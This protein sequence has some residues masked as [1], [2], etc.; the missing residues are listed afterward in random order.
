MAI[1]SLSCLRSVERGYSFSPTKCA[2]ISNDSAPK[3][4]YG[5]DLSKVKSFCYLGIDFTACGIDEIGNAKRRTAKADGVIKSLARLGV[6]SPVL[7]A[8]SLVQL[9]KSLVR[10]GLLPLLMTKKGDLVILE[11]YQL[12][13]LKQML[14]LPKL[15]LND[16]VYAVAACPPLRMRQITLRHSRLAR[17]RGRCNSDWWTED[18]LVVAKKGWGGEEFQ[19]DPS[20]ARPG[21]EKLVILNDLFIEPTNQLLRSRFDGELSYAIVQKVTKLK[22][23]PGI[24][25]LLSLWIVRFWRNFKTRTCKK[26]SEIIGNQHHVVTCAQ[27]LSKLA[28]DNL[29]PP[30]FPIDPPRARS[31][32]LVIE[33]RIRSIVMK[34]QLKELAI[35]QLEALGHHLISSSSAVYGPL[36]R[37]NYA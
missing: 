6:R 14:N 25:R 24:F 10:P 29:L 13:L 18:A 32:F 7:S 8:R 2:V 26:C 20:L 5:S 33:E 15:A 12:M 1:I 21:T 3:R 35:A 27:L 22:V 37:M 11:N 9:F 17:L 28:A 34:Q 19:E 4:L 16:Y 23:A 36:D 31:E 30:L